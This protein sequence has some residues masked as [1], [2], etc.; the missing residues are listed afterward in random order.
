MTTLVNSPGFKSYFTRHLPDMVGRLPHPAI[1]FLSAG[2]GLLCFVVDRH[3]CRSKTSSTMRLALGCSWPQALLLTARQNCR[4]IRYLLDGLRFAASSDAQVLLRLASDKGNSEEVMARLRQR[5][6]VILAASFFACFQHVLL[7]GLL[8]AKENDARLIVVRPAEDPNF[9]QF[10]VRAETIANYPL[11][12]IELGGSSSALKIRNALISGAIVVCMMDNIVEGASLVPTTMFGR[13]S[14]LIAGYL[15]LARKLQIPI[16]LCYGRHS[17]GSFA[18]VLK[19]PVVDSAASSPV[20]GLEHFADSL[21]SL[22]ETEVRAAPHLWDGW[23]AL[24]E[25]WT[26]G[27]QLCSDDGD[28]YADE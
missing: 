20:E 27:S 15:L 5:K 1:S 18:L 9:D 23:N 26:I 8:R 19:G 4:A 10:R 17:G 7:I 21:N 12:V 11:E 24:H 25:K 13:P 28:N 6:G 22:L 3:G 14:C 16:Y 2:A